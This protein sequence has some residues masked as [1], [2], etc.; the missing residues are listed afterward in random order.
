MAAG[1]AGAAGLAI[2]GGPVGWPVGAIVGATAWV[3]LGRLEPAAVRRRRLQVAAALPLAA[4]LLAAAMSSGSPP[5]RAVDAAGRAVGGPLGE[6]LR[7]AAAAMRYGA[8]PATAWAGLLIDPAAR[9][10]G[11]AMVRVVVRGAPPAAVLERVAKDAR[12]VARWAAEAQARS[13][14]ARAAAP[15][16]LCFLPAF[17]LIGIVP[18][19]ATIGMPLLP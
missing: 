2:V 5:E 7:A 19:V 13:L 17:V 12:D 6:A 18:L 11:R 4:E 3:G 9:P 15:L 1:L 16:G 10:L 8:D 14:G